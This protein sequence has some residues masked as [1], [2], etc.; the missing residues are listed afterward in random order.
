MPDGENS[1][2]KEGKRESA[3]EYSSREICPPSLLLQ[4]L[5]RAHSIFL[6]HHAPSLAQLYT[7]LT[8]LKFCGAL[9]RFWNK[10]LLDWDVLLS[11]NPAVDIHNGLKLAAGGELGI[12]VGEEE[13]G[14][15][16]REVLEGFVSRTEGLV[17][18]I[19][20][21]FGDSPGKI[22]AISDT[23]TRNSSTVDLENKR[24]WLG[25]GRVPRPA[26]GVI[27]SGIGAVTRPSVRDLS[28]WMEW[29]Y[30]YGRNAYGV[31]D[32]PH[33]ARR[34]K[35]NAIAPKA[36][37]DQRR[38]VRSTG[39]PEND[40]PRSIV[41]LS[42]DPS[43]A[44][45]TSK[46]AAQEGEIVEAAKYVLS[47][48]E[49]S[50]P[51]T[52]TLIKYLTLGVYG[53]SWGIPSKRA[54][55]HRQVSEHHVQQSGRDVDS[56]SIGKIPIQQIESK[57]MNDTNTRSEPANGDEANG[58]FLIGLQGNLENEDQDPVDD[59]GNGTD[60]GTDRELGSGKVEWNSRLLL[61]TLHVKRSKWKKS[62]TNSSISC[63]WD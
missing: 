44:A 7:R 19:V 49:E 35:K 34:K 42:R 48:E 24:I 20:S 36:S 11:G 28:A 16:E 43:I 40:I 38:S 21:R 32:N 54:Q 37:T 10:F 52:E 15:G 45:G 1:H 60:T 50:P 29:I 31:A 6:L 56:K 55:V 53:S 27:F 47:H 46:S 12:G 8:R 33:S 13:W 5:L 30:K 22:D 17:D 26:D 9:E 61:R 4:H 25:A 41:T 23:S 51:A 18:L 63:E 2:L 14:S 39:H 59:E 62:D 3:V 57:A 58:S